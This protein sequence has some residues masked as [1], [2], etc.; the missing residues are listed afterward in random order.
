M[1]I[2]QVNYK[3][4]ASYTQMFSNLNRKTKSAQTL[5]SLF[6]AYAPQSNSL[7]GGKGSQGSPE[8]SHK[9]PYAIEGMD[10]TGR[11]DW[12][13]IIPVSSEMVDHVIED[14][15]TSFYKYAGMSGGNVAEDDAYYAKIIDYVK[16]LDPKDRSPATWTLNQVHFNVVGAVT[17]ALKERIPNWEAGQA[18]NP[19]I[20]DEI[21]SDESI[22]QKFSQGIP[23]RNQGG[24][25]MTV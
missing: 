2:S 9:N 1:R 23:I 19:E 22:T 4:Y 13:K 18:I 5:S 25:D 17:Q 3:N 14:V 24:F 12:K 8:K 21:F 20:L 7:F 6:G 15:K 16:T 11:T 10:I